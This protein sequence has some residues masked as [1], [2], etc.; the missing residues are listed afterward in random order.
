MY[1]EYITNE[2]SV[3]IM[4][5]LYCIGFMVLLSWDAGGLRTDL[6][7]WIGLRLVKL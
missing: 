7:A 4:F 1:L 3:V 5:I 2:Y 6:V